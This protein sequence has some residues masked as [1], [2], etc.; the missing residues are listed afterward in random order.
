MGLSENPLPRRA[1]SPELCCA[2][3]H[4]APVSRSRLP[5]WP[6]ARAVEEGAA[7]GGGM[8]G[9]WTRSE[10]QLSLVLIVVLLYHFNI[11]SFVHRWVHRDLLVGRR[12]PGRLPVACE[13]VFR[14]L[15][16]TGA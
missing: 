15:P 3:V 1:I 2:A 7:A 16:S 5:A 10:K 13:H 11:F 12:A 6:A 8:F 9:T 4:T 14:C